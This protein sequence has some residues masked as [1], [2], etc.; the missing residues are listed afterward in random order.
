MKHFDGFHEGASA[1]HVDRCIDWHHVQRPVVDRIELA[2]F[3]RVADVGEEV[4]DVG[5]GLRLSEI[6]LID[7]D[8]CVRSWEQ[9][10]DC[11][12]LITVV[13]VISHRLLG[14]HRDVCPDSWA[15]ESAIFVFIASDNVT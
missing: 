11:L 13:L 4:P 2:W 7:A 5:S 3:V 6:S 8:L 9:Q 12:W 1:D 14:L 10:I 15:T